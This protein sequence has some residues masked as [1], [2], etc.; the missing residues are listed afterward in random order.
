[1]GMEAFAG[2]GALA[3]LPLG[4]AADIMGEDAQPDAR[5]HGIIAPISTA[6]EPIFPF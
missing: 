3:S 5:R 6:P 2:L 4:P 1:M